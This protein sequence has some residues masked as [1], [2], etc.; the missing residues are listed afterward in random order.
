MKYRYSSSTT[1]KCIC[2]V[3]FR[4]Y[5]DFGSSLD[6]NTGTIGSDYDR[7][8]LCIV[9]PIITPHEQRSSKRQILSQYLQYDMFH[10]FNICVPTY[11]HHSIKRTGSIK[12]P[13]LKFFKKSLLN[14]PYDPKFW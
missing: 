7:S 4:F 1:R 9:D 2:S 5:L 11:S 14:I 10:R 13:G 3:V 8:R 12:R 6:L